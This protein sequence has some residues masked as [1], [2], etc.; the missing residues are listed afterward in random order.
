MFLQHQYPI[1]FIIIGQTDMSDKLVKVY[2][3]H[4]VYTYLYIEIV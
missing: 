2:V 3:G 1:N 4:P